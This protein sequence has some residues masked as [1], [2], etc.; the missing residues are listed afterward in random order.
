MTDSS[1]KIP[2]EAQ[3]LLAMLRG[4][5]A[6]TPPTAPAPAPR[7]PSG[8]LLASFPRNAREEVRLTWDTLTGKDGRPRSF[9]SVRLWAL[10]RPGLWKPTKEGV[11]IRA[12]ELREL[13]AVVA[14]LVARLEA[15]PGGS[16]GS[17]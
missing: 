11:T 10:A 6:N 15:A 9:L 13:L 2:P 16:D 5:A 12:R 14:P 7:E 8:E 4:R 3:A 17:R 1:P